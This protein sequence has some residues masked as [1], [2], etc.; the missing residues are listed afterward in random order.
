MPAG[1]RWLDS[2]TLAKLSSIPAFERLRYDIV[3]LNSTRTYFWYLPL[4]V[5]KKSDRQ[6]RW[7]ILGHLGLHH[8]HSLPETSLGDPCSSEDVAGSALITIGSHY[9][10]RVTGRGDKRGA[11]DGDCLFRR[12]QEHPDNEV[13]HTFSAIS[14]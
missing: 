11:E 7:R 6:N 3:R 1:R 8:Y 12:H 2:E 5:I 10:S 14:S 13:D 4:C 9:R